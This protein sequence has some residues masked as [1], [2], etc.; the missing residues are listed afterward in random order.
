MPPSTLDSL[1]DLAVPG[2][3]RQRTRAGKEDTMAK[4]KKG[5]PQTPGP[6]A[7]KDPAGKKKDRKL[8]TDKAELD[9]EELDDVSGG[10]LQVEKVELDADELDNRVGGWQKDY[11]NCFGI[12]LT[13]RKPRRRSPS[14]HNGRLK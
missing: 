2:R 1:L 10:R 9:M 3:T 11:D 4:Q 13:P 6:G 8:Q 14:A 12:H 7:G 5:G